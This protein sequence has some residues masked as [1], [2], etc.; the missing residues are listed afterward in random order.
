MKTS[1]RTNPIILATLLGCLVGS[2]HALAATPWTNYVEGFETD[3][4]IWGGTT[5]R[6]A[7]GTYG[8]KAAAGAYYALATSTGEKYPAVA[9]VH[10][11]PG[12]YA[13]DM[14]FPGAI[15]AS[16]DLYLDMKSGTDGQKFTFGFD[17]FYSNGT[18]NTQVALHAV[19]AASGWTVM[20]SDYSGS[21]AT[22]TVTD[23]GWY[24]FQNRFYDNG[25][26]F[27]ADESKVIK[28]SDSSTVV[29]LAHDYQ[30]VPS[31]A[32]KHFSGWVQVNFS[33]LEAI[34]NKAAG[35]EG[36]AFDNVSVVSDKKP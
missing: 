31:Q 36:I 26:G 1:A 24:T 32:I 14:E 30:D 12:Q 35:C 4:G 8:I 13:S 3:I 21:S 27:M 29:S 7:S 16:V 28:K 15:L 18:N 25:R 11:T 34:Q 10:I 33:V 23:T 22:V 5:K 20:L 9:N 2:M 19:K 17:S 6:I